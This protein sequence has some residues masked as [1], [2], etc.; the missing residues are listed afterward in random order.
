[1]TPTEF[2]AHWKRL[3]EPDALQQM[4]AAQQHMLDDEVIQAMKHQVSL[5]IQANPQA[6]L[7]QAG[8]ILFA[9][10]LTG[11]LLHQAWGLMA[12]G[13]VYKQLA[14]Y[15]Q[16]IDDY[17]QARAVATAA[18]HPLEAA[19]SQ[20]GK[21]FSL[22]SLGFFDEALDLCQT[23]RQTFVE[24]GDLVAAARVDNSA[25]ITLYKLGD[26]HQASRLWGRT[27]E[28]FARHSPDE[29]PDL[30]HADLNLS[31]VLRNLN[32]YEESIRR[33][34]SARSLAEQRR[35]P[36][37]I[38][39][40]QQSRAV[41]HYYLGQYNKA[42]RLISE[43]RQTFKQ[44]G[45][46]RD[47]L[48]AGL[49]LADCHLALNRF[50]ETRTLAQQS[51]RGL[52][53]FGMSYEVAGAAYTCARAHLGLGDFDEANLC[54]LQAR[55]IFAAI[56][57][58]LWEAAVDVQRAKL[59]LLLGQP[60]EAIAIAEGAGQT[61]GEQGLAFEQAR[62][63]LLAA[64]AHVVRKNLEEAR[65]RA[66]RSLALA[67]EKNLP[68]LAQRGNHLLGRLAEARGDKVRAYGYYQTCLDQIEQLRQHVALEMWGSFLTDKDA[69]YQDAVRL[70]LEM[71]PAETAFNYV[72]RA[73]S[74]ALV[75]MIA[76][77]LDVRVRVRR[78]VDR[79]LIEQIEAVRQRCRWL[80]G[81]LNLSPEHEA[82]D[83]PHWQRERGKLRAELSRQERIL[84]ALLTELQIR[85]AD[86]AED[87]SLLT[88]QVEAPQ[89]HLDDQ[90]VLLEYYI[91]GDEV[92]A[93]TV[94]RREMQVHRHLCAGRDLDRL[95][96]LLRLSLGSFTNLNPNAVDLL[97]AHRQKL[98]AILQRLHQFL[99]E[100]LAPVLA[101]FANL[102]VVPSGPLHYL[103]FHALH[104]GREYL[105]EQIEISY[106]PCASLLRLSQE[107]GQNTPEW[108]RSLVMASSARGRLPFTLIEAQKIGRLL[109]SP[110][111]LEAEAT[112]RTLLKNAAECQVIHLAAH[113]EF[114]PDAPQF[115]ALHLEDGPLTTVDIFNLDLAASLVTLSACQSG[116]SV[117]TG[118]DELVGFSRAF[119]YAGACSLLLSLWRVDDEATTPLMSIFY[120]NLLDG[121]TKAAALRQAQLA[122]L[123]H[124][125]EPALQHP[126]FWAPFFLVGARGHL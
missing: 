73:K 59:F 83:Y 49:F 89:P 46:E 13:N 119:L 20:I 124:T 7:A 28:I 21:I 92:F 75:D 90:T 23:I 5:T 38:A 14:R 91:A 62:A 39:R 107:R 99:I 31:V 104:G 116:R 25:A 101:D 100:P 30:P 64:E 47:F 102:I 50:R 78:P 125:A 40:A 51:E 81:R 34:N 106:L 68:Q 71:E 41:T 93:F 80:A 12:R 16:S 37:V 18:G 58:V 87:V 85:A 8:S 36:V 66:Q 96:T 105:V 27:R 113:A 115:S 48:V 69:A 4:I 72:E 82:A 65:E 42:L 33:A 70:A 63:E 19:R 74:R 95:L 54:L 3:T 1:M 126:F 32:R 98:L 15:S 57:S 60:Q 61:F 76:H 109:A 121:Q 67:E 88:V 29:G 43:A 10:S 53:G 22:T 118:G 111:Y 2:L 114:R 84:E 122:L 55:S 77:N 44:E 24:Q 26:Y 123:H 56:G 97:A 17:D 103:P 9:A 35:L 86:Y 108:Q 45:L 11:Q 110:P 6:A 94:G 52:A 117:V 112:S 79:P 120:Q